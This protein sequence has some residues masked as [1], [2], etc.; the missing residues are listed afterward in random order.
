MLSREVYINGLSEIRDFRCYHVCWLIGHIV[1][2]AVFTTEAWWVLH[3][4]SATVIRKTRRIEDSVVVFNSWDVPVEEEKVVLISVIFTSERVI[5]FANQVKIAAP[6]TL[7]TAL[8]IRTA[9]VALSRMAIWGA[10]TSATYS[11]RLSLN[12]FSSLVC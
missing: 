4:L 1:F 10:L 11:V 2:S 3:D 12:F 8:A 6:L 9:T 7:L 5:Y